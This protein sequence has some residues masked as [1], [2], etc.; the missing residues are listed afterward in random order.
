MNQTTFLL[1]TDVLIDFFKKLPAAI[2]L[3]TSL[4]QGHRLVISIL[5]ISELRTGWTEKEAKS[6]LP[7]LYKAFVILP[8]SLEAA[9][10][11]GS[12]RRLYLSKGLSLPTID[13]IIAAQA[14]TLKATLITR[15]KKH[16][17]M[18]ELKIYKD[19]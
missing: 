12:I 16:Y 2:K 9:E 11:A 10:T 6:L 17:P 19:Y 18:N 7:H 4:A 15:N 1:D 8:I 3:I 14:I 13:T 5:S